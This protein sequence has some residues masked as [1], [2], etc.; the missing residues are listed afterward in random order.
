MSQREARLLCLRDILEHLT[1]N[2]QRLEWATDHETIQV[3]TETMIRDLERCLRLCEE[4]QPRG[5]SRARA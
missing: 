2:Q 1:A 3:L 5:V 4:L